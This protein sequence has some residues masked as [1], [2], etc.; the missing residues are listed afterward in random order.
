M[1]DISETCVLGF[2]VAFHPGL[3]T[4]TTFEID[5]EVCDVHRNI[6]MVGKS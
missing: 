4:E 5:I 1:T 2:M 3:K 6:E